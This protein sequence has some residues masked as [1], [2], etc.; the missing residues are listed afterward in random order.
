MWCMT[1][2]AALWTA[3][4]S[5]DDA[6]GSGATGGTAG[7]GGATATGG[8]GTGGNGAAGGGTGGAVPDDCRRYLTAGDVTSSQFDGVITASFDSNT[9]TLTTEIGDGN[10]AAI[11]AEATYDSVDEFV[12]EAKTMGR[13]LMTGQSYT[14]LMDAT[15][16]YQYDASD[17]LVSHDHSE[18][19]GVSWTRTYAQWDGQG[20]PT[21]GTFDLDPASAD[22]TGATLTVT[23][24]DGAR[25]RTIETDFSTGTGA[26]CPTGPPQSSWDEFDEDGNP[27]AQDH[28]DGN[29]WTYT[30]TA[31]ETICKP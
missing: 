28:G 19:G 26:D 11:T 12:D 21:D 16:T 31:T 8:S 2:A 4:C 13:W 22:C 25:R 7:T 30:T 27:T 23:Y 6:G 15:E 14:G 3:G 17:Q 24:D 9:L 18:S 5:D 20:R 1:V 29:V 10:T